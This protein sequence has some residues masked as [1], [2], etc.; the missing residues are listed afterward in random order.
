[1][2]LVTHPPR[3]NL[4]YSKKTR[5]LHCSLCCAVVILLGWTASGSSKISRD[6]TKNPSV[7]EVEA[8]GDI[9]AIGDPHGDYRRLATLLKTAGLISSVPDY[10]A[11]VVWSGGNA[12]LVV[13]GDMIHK[14]PQSL[15]VVR[16]LRALIAAGSRSGGHVLIL[17]RN[18]EAEFLA[19]PHGSK[20][21]EFAG[22][23]R[24]AHL[25]PIDVAAC[26]GEI[27]EFLC[28]LPMAAKVNDW[29]FCHAGNTSGRTLSQL[30]TDLERGVDRDGFAT[31]QLVGGNSLLEARLTL[32][33]KGGAQWVDMGRAHRPAQLL[34]L[35]ASSLGVLHLVQGHQPSYVAFSDGPHRKAGEMFQRDGL[36]F[37]VDTGMSQGVDDSHGAALH[38]TRRVGGETEATA[39]CSNGRATRIWDST[40]KPPIG[41]AAPCH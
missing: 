7:I 37:L 16:L 25:D 29:F 6:W 21:G 13:M 30:R 39:V 35:F 23:L 38:V 10:P 41:R 5:L 14:G 8:P 1:M 36:L 9:W 28:G 17:M 3:R 22:E 11:G 12:V 32:K 2:R 31:E 40:L 26:H 20:T 19:D 33:G 4:W 24:G 15:D 27:G 18:H 34:A